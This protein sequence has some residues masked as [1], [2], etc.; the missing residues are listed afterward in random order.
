MK[1]H[2][3]RVIRLI[4]V[5]LSLVPFA[6]AHAQQVP[7]A[8]QTGGEAEDATMEEVVVTGSRIVRS[9]FETSTPVAVFDSD[10]LAETGETNLADVFR[11]IPAIGIG[12]GPD[13]SVFDQDPGATFVNLRNLGIERTLVLVD[14]R[15]RVPG[16]KFSGAV[17]VSTIPVS[18]IERLEIMTGGGSAVYGADAVTG[19][20]NIILKKDFEGVEASV[21]GGW[22]DN[23]GADST[24]ASLLAGSPFASGSGR[25]TFGASYNKQ[26]PLFPL[27][28]DWSAEPNG[29]MLFGADPDSSSFVTTLD[30]YRFTDTAEGGAFWALSPDY[31]SCARYTVD[32]N[33]RV[34]ENDYYPFDDPVLGAQC[35]SWIAAGGDGFS[36]SV[37]GQLRSEIEMTTAM[38]TLEYDFSDTL[39]G[40]VNLDMARGESFTLG[41]PAF[42]YDTVVLRSNPIIPAD[43]A[44]LMDAQ[45]FFNGGALFVSG[46][47]AN[48]GPVSTKNERDTFTLALGL[49]GDIGKFH[50]DAAY[51]RGEFDIDTTI[52]NDRREERY[53]AAIDVISDPQGG[54]PVCR[55]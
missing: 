39:T 34:T 47:H 1:T 11:K 29:Y 10:F 22:S 33:L 37:Y 12:L 52:V 49:R 3:W 45:A 5:T 36:E 50:W 15:R 21:T 30:N 18:M 2:A 4:L 51:Q 43:V 9:S 31:T 38:G 54:A 53:F 13:S 8:S 55:D 6:A 19:V 26:D 17:D 7:A 14:G 16:T 41:Q 20:V 48:L 42:D 44:A 40:F 28:R 35:A 25:F 32:P 23:G 46:T 27:D 24:Q